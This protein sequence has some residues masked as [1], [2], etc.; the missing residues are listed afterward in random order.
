MIGLAQ[1]SESKP[2]LIPSADQYVSA[3]GDQAAQLEGHY[4]F[5]KGAAATQALLG[6]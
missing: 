5:C 2:V 6:H 1:G 3:S 4:T